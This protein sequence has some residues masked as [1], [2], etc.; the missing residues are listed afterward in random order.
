MYVK[1]DLDKKLTY[2]INNKKGVSTIV[3]TVILIA[4]VM[5]L[6][7]LIWGVINSLVRKQMGSTE[8]CFGNFGK[9]N[10]NRQYTCWDNLNSYLQFSISIGDIDVN[11]LIVSISSEAGSK[12]FY[13]NNTDSQ[14]GNLANYVATGV[15]GFGTDLIRLPG[16]NEGKTYITNY[17]T[18]MPDSIT[19]VPIINGQQCEASDS[20][21]S[22]ENCL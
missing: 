12:T 9:I 14:I 20:I 17:T 13:I 8:S 1:S 10:L 22:I 3:V 15:P 16:K 21:K 18:V 6:S 11:N 4:L 2:K 19:L 5:G 7:V